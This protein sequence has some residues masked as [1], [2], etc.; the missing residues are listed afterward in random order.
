MLCMIRQ[1]ELWVIFCFLFKT[2]TFDILILL[3]GWRFG[4]I[5]CLKAVVKL[6]IKFC[7]IILGVRTQKPELGWYHL[8]IIALERSL[9]YWLK[10][11]DN[12]D[13]LMC[14]VYSERIMIYNRS[15]LLWFNK[16][17]QKLDDYEFSYL[18][19][20]YNTPCLCFKTIQYALGT[21]LFCVIQCR[22]KQNITS[23]TFVWNV[24][25]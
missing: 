7:K 9:R 11:K 19:N 3:Y 18:T 22:M 16:V 10:M 5:Y 17:K 8:P 2:V 20:S 12:K 23:Y 21:L 13:S 6:Q 1:L 4:G 15:N 25:I 24:M 14:T